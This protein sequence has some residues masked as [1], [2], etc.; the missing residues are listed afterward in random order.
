[1]GVAVIVHAREATPGGSSKTFMLIGWL[2]THASTTSGASSTL[3]AS[4]ANPR[5]P[6]SWCTCSMVEGNSLAQY[7]HQV[8]QK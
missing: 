1:M 4:T 2:R 6:Y 5:A 7:G 3:I 8:A